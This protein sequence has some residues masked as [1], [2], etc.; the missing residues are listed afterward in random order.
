[1]WTWRNKTKCF[2]TVISAHKNPK[3]SVTLRWIAE[4]FRVLHYA[5]RFHFPDRL[6]LIVW[7]P[8]SVSLWGHPW[9]VSLCGLWRFLR[10]RRTI[11]GTS[12]CGSRCDSL[13]AAVRSA[14]AFVSSPTV[15]YSAALQHCRPVD[16]HRITRKG[17]PYQRVSILRSEY[18]E[19]IHYTLK[20]LFLILQ[21]RMHVDSTSNTLNVL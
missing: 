5:H 4:T 14:Q 19:R 21:G 1:M 20:I 2:S 18:N 16:V 11:G 7:K 10:E 8:C 17:Q 12:C 3:K 9:E 6:R 13:Q 15:Y